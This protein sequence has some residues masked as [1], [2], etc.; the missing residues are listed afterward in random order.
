MKLIDE[1]SQMPFAIAIVGWGFIFLGIYG[2]FGLVCS[3]VLFPIMNLIILN[4]FEK[5][6]EA[7]NNPF[8]MFFFNHWIIMLFYSAVFILLMIVG[9]INYLRKKLWAKYLLEGICWYHI[10]FSGI[11]LYFLPWMNMS[12]LLTIFPSNTPSNNLMST[13][14]GEYFGL[15]FSL[16]FTIGYLCVFLFVIAYLHSRKIKNVFAYPPV[17]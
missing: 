17:V 4:Y 11:N 7:T 2:L 3:V 6:I 15:A 14:I 13:Q 1:I 5:V 12:K 10:I 9:G 16:L 8:S